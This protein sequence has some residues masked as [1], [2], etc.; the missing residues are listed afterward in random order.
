MNV[1]YPDQA[2]LVILRMLSKNAKLTS[3]ELAPATGLSQ[4]Q[5]HK[6]IRNLEK[7]GYIL[8]Y[9]TVIN[10]KALGVSKICYAK[11][12]IEEGNIESL[13][14]FEEITEAHKLHSSD[15]ANGW[16]LLLKIKLKDSRD[17]KEWANYNLLRTG[18]CYSA[19]VWEIAGTY[20]NE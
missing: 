6:R 9:Q 4:S 14:N 20:F 15:H 19:E 12:A 11:V 1:Y 10:D 8:S 3:R 2:D 13:Q 5:V 18:I 7:T 16:F 17:G